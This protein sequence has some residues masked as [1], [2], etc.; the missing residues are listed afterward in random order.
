MEVVV[1]WPDSGKVLSHFLAGTS[2][3]LLLSV[4]FDYPGCK[5]LCG[6]L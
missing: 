5:E 2:S 3:P 4:A 6:F 1:D